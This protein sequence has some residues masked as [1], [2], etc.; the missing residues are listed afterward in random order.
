M[1]NKVFYYKLIAYKLFIRS[2]W[3]AHCIDCNKP[4]ASVTVTCSVY[5]PILY[6]LNEKK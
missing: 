1:I 5:F 3:I 2:G 6:L 4:Q